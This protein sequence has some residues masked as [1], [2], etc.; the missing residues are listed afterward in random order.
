[1]IFLSMKFTLALIFSM[2]VL[3]KLV[4][5]KSFQISILRFGLVNRK[6]IPLLSLFFLICEFVGAA[7][8]MLNSTI[9]IIGYILLSGLIVVFSYAIW[10]SLRNKNTVS[11]GCFG[12]S[13]IPITNVDLVRN[14]IILGLILG[15]FQLESHFHLDVTL[16]EVASIAFLSLGFAIMIAFFSD[17]Y[18]HLRS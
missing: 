18:W 16:L 17:F 9:A 4:D 5:L 6:H 2:S 3:S 1:M 15:S 11:C 8:I 7:L 13:T 10:I 12:K 14:F